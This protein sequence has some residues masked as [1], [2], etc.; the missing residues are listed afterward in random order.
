MKNVQLT[1]KW[2]PNL[3]SSWPGAML[4]IDKTNIKIPTEII[5]EWLICIES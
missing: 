1:S 3:M 5:T 4:T 2:N